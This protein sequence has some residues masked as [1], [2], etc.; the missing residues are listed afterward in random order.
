MKILLAALVA[1]SA[2]TSAAYAADKPII[3][4]APAWVKPVAPPAT[5][6]KADEAPIR[7]LLAS[8]HRERLA[9]FEHV[10]DLVTTADQK[11]VDRQDIGLGSPG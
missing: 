11:L 1:T 6:A 3:G 9:R 10:D 2:L 8:K 5:S 7:I 4:P